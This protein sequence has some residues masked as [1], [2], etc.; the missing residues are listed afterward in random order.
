MNQENSAFNQKASKKVGEK[1]GRT[2]SCDCNK[3]QIIGLVSLVV[4]AVLLIFAIV[5]ASGI[6]G[7][8]KIA[9]ASGGLTIASMFGFGTAAFLF[10]PKPEALGG[11]ENV[12]RTP[13]QS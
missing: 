3:K 1:E 12:L 7:V 13:V 6:F 2:Y 9:F 8:G 4:A 11:S 5:L 10:A